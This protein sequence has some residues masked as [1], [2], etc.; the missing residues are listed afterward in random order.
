MVNSHPLPMAEISGPAT[1][2]PTQEQMLRTKL[3][4]ATPDEA[5]RGMN[6]VNIVVAAAKMSM[7]PM[8]KKKLA[9]N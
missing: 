6:S 9:I 8:P 3:F 1:M 5:R 4:T 7:L 2:A